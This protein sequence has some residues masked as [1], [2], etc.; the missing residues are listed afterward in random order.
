[1]SYCDIFKYLILSATF[2]V[3]AETEAKNGSRKW[4]KTHYVEYL[5]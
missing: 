3:Y 2:T 4:E 5:L 1:M